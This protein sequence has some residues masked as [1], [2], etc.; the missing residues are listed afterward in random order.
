[1]TFEVIPGPSSRAA[2]K[3]LLVA[4]GSAFAILVALFITL[5]LEIDAPGWIYVGLVVAA[6]IAIR[7]DFVMIRRARREA[8]AGYTVSGV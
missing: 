6:V 3:F 4:V 8:E 7:Q 2:A 1:M 5:M